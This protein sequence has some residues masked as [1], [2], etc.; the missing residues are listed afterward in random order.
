MSEQQDVIEE[1]EAA[2]VL[3][4]LR[5]AYRSA[6][7]RSLNDYSE[8]AGHNAAWLGT[9]RF[10]LF[11]NRL[12]RVFTCERYSISTSSEADPNAALDQLFEEL[13]KQD[14]RTMPRLDPGLVHRADLNTSPGWAHTGRRFLLAAC[15][16]GKI[17]RLPW[18]QRS[19]TKQSVA[20]QRN[21]EPAPT[22]FDGFDDE[23]EIDG[24]VA[25]NTAEE[26]DLPT[27]VVAHTLDPLTG[28]PE[29]VYGRPR[30]NAGGGKGW[31]WYEHLLGV[32]PIEGG[33]R[34]DVDAPLP[35]GPS[36][37]ADAAVY[38]RQPV[39]ERRGDR[40]SGEQ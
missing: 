27:F 4:G 39:E 2:G 11:Q 23:E 37:V 17:D 5:W 15:K 30:L 14:I 35:S 12:D 20:R 28:V 38:L 25:L 32:P 3:N 13:T 33:Y 1:L 8:G 36:P 19:P 31:H 16:P 6:V 18:P 22:L 40:A 9:T 29:L 34:T 7:A 24:L 26:L 10:T 21:P